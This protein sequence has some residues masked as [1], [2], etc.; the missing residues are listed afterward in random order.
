[1]AAIELTTYKDL[2]DHVVDFLGANPSGEAHRDARRAVLA[3]LRNLASAHR[4]FYYFSRGHLA[5]AAPYSLG[6]VAYT[7][8]TGLY[9]RLVTLTDGAWPEWAALGTVVLG[10]IAYDVAA[11]YS[12]TLL[13]LSAASNP[14]M[15]LAPA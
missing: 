12:S 5:T 1:M 3:G 7:H 11:R 15:D 9:P 10:N 13:G 8:S 14:G 2:I 6:T 4:W